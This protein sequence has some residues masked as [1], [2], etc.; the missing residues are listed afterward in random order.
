MSF[1]AQTMIKI[2]EDLQAV[3]GNDRHFIY[4]DHH[5]SAI[6]D[7]KMVSRN[8][9]VPFYGIQNIYYAACELT[10]EYFFPQQKM[11]EIVRLLGRYDC[12][13]HKGTDEEQKVTEFQYG[14]R[15]CIGSRKAAYSFLISSLQGNEE[16]DISG[17]MDIGKAIYDYL[18]V[19]AKNALKLG[20]EIKLS[21]PK[22][23]DGVFLNITETFR[24]LA[25]NKD[26]FN[27]GNF[28]IDYIKEGYDGAASFYYNGKSWLFSL[29]SSKD[30]VDVSEI[31]KFYGGGGH[32]GA[33][34]FQVKNINNIIFE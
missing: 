14:A 16:K 33:A 19:D 32:K 2:Y 4:I 31:A 6:N 10:W 23:T 18:C 22:S 34:G 20:F 26:R 7:I 27:P 3:K 12:F 5:V 30:D 24:F 25:F 29:Y 1:P 9:D 28:D 13:G 21:I 15:N 11:P 17:I 8:G